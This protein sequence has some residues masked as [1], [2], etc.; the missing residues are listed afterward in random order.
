[1]WPGNKTVLP[2]HGVLTNPDVVG[3]ADSVAVV[4]ISTNVGL[5][6]IELKSNRVQKVSNRA[7]QHF[8]IPY[9]S[10]YTLDHVT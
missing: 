1:M 3:F 8:V 2:V 7:V 6:T 10:F 4:F 5:F 9:T